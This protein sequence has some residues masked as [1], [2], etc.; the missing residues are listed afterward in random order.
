MYVSNRSALLVMCLG[1]PHVIQFAFIISF[2][3]RSN[4]LSL[5]VSPCLFYTPWHSLALWHP[6]A[7]LNKSQ[8]ASFWRVNNCFWLFNLPDFCFD[9]VFRLSSKFTWT[10]RRQKAKQTARFSSCLHSTYFPLSFTLSLSPSLCVCAYDLVLPQFGDL[11]NIA[12]H[13]LLL[14]FGFCFC[15]S[16][17]CCVFFCCCCVCVGFNRNANAP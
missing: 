16:R 8:V 6:L 9:L 5:T 4:S 3:I 2:V 12:A 10:A 11:E 13:C 14:F 17:V 1:N 7:R 15:F